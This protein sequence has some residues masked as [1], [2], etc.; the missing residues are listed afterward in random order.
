MSQILLRSMLEAGVLG[1]PW[2]CW[3]AGKPLG[4]AG[5]PWEVL[6][7]WEASGRCWESLG[8]SAT[9]GSLWEVLEVPG[10]C[11]YAGNAVFFAGINI[12]LDME[13]TR[14]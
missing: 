6:L 11:C 12:P 3:N 4:G 2:D 10:R 13:W 9:L 5:S 1:G 7:Y 14:F 8:G